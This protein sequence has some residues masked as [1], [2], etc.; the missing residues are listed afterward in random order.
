MCLVLTVVT[1]DWQ[2]MICCNSE[3]KRDKGN[4]YAKENGYPE[5]VNV[6]QPR[7]RGFVTCLSQL[8]GSLDAGTHN[9]SLVDYKCI[10]YEQF[11]ED[12]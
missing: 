5:L 6:L 9:R 1:S 12:Y 10:F 4:A 2:C 11:R 8:R 7:T 3:A